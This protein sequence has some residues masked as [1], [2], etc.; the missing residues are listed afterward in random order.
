MKMMFPSSARDE[1]ASYNYTGMKSGTC[2][3]AHLYLQIHV[4]FIAITST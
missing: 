1:F 3:A 2:Q 4:R